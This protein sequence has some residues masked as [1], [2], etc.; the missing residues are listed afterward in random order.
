MKLI[1]GLVVVLIIIG[2][3]YYFVCNS[4][5]D[6]ILLEVTD[7]EYE[8]SFGMYY[9]ELTTS[10]EYTGFLSTTLSERELTLYINEINLG[11]IGFSEAWEKFNSGSKNEYTGTYGTSNEEDIDE[12]T[13]AST[14]NIVIKF[15]ANAQVGI[16]KKYIEKRAE[17]SSSVEHW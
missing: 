11:T 16:I 5:A 12:L 9:I 4:S 3:G 8:T 13:S 2:G 10:I 15:K 17:S 6:S 7:W 14:Y 1:G